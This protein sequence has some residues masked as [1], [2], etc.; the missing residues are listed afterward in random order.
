MNTRDNK[1]VILK[2]IFLMRKS[3]KSKR[4]NCSVISV[5]MTIT[6]LTIA[7]KS[8]N[9]NSNKDFE[10]YLKQKE[11]EE[12]KRS[13]KEN[14]NTI[15]DI[16]VT[17]E[18]LVLSVQF[19]DEKIENT[20]KNMATS[21]FPE[22]FNLMKQLMNFKIDNKVNIAND[23]N[24][25]LH[26]FDQVKRVDKE[27]S[28]TQKIAFILN[29]LPEKYRSFAV[30][31]ESKGIRNSNQFICELFEEIETFITKEEKWNNNLQQIQ[32]QVE[33]TTQKNN[34]IGKHETLNSNKREFESGSLIM[35]SKPSQSTSPK[36][37]KKK[38]SKKG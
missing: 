14:M 18:D 22:L 15:D 25:L 10:K 30:G 32:G 16:D 31:S 3:T 24:F 33:K 19:R 35:Q 23:V 34:S 12:S 20:S 6:A 21:I 26:L 1:T 9:I 37:Q 28:D 8:S 2:R 36:M 13:E 27:L 4:T 11:D 29:A 38:R 5:K 17:E 7:S